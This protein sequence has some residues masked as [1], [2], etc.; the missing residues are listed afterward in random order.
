MPGGKWYHTKTK[1]I[2]LTQTI[3]TAPSSS[4]QF[5]PTMIASCDVKL[6]PVIIQLNVAQLQRHLA[7][8]AE[9]EQDE[10]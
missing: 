2:T 1:Y 9:N 4:L 10:T 7:E 8:S 3:N 6:V 5:A